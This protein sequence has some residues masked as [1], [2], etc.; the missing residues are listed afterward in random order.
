VPCLLILGLFWMPRVII[1]LL[2]IFTDYIGRAFDSFLWP[3]LG[4]IFAPT[5]TLAWAW[6]TNTRG[7][8]GGIHLVIVAVALLFDLGVFGGGSRSWFLRRRTS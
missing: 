1:V 6:M 2:V 8:A 4:F 5:T 7:E 3:L